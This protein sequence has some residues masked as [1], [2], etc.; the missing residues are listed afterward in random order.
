MARIRSLHPGQWTD[1]DFVACSFPARLLAL[2]LRNEADDN[3]VFEWKPL[4]I[5][6]R[7]FPADPV[8]VAALLDELSANR[9]VAS[10]EESGKRY[11]VIR[12]FRRWQRP[13]KPKSWHPLP[14]TL[15]S[16]AGLVDDRAPTARPPVADRSPN[17]SAEV[18]GRRKEEDEG[19]NPEEGG[20]A[21]APAPSPPEPDQ[22][23]SQGGALAPAPAAQPDRDPDDLLPIAL[24][25]TTEGEAVR[26]W[27]AMAVQYDLPAVAKLT[28]A[29][30]RALRARLRDAGGIEGITA[31]IE[32]VSRS[33]FC[34]GSSD[35]G[36]RAD[37]DWFVSER[38]FTRLME[39][40]FDDREP[41][42][43]GRRDW[44][45]FERQLDQR[46]GSA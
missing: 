8:D 39:G 5:K 38:G 41:A 32:R 36:W 35:R 7:L 9:Q 29:R 37:F 40:K 21:G 3:G 1:E 20:G 13:D 27:N 17:S 25:R 45:D 30:R 44:S 34:R 15:R 23:R 16:Y 24:D 10:F 28:E 46:M 11:G 19:G 42:A 12:N 14:D 33:A 18:G 4:A 22:P 2:A 31:A 43:G 6:M 26:R